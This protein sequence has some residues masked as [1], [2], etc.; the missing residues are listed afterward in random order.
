MAGRGHRG[1]K[2]RLKGDPEE[3]QIHRVALR[4]GKL[5]HEVRAMTVADF[6]AT[7]AFLDILDEEARRSRA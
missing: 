5:P 1:R 4:Y 6:V 7:V 2:K 3:T